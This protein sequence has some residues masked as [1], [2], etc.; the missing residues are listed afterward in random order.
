MARTIRK[1]DLE[2]I[3]EESFAEAIDEAR[4]LLSLSDLL[5][6]LLTFFVMLFAISSPDQKKLT[7]MTQAMGSHLGVGTQRKIVAPNAN[8]MEGVRTKVKSLITDNNLVNDVEL[9]SDS[10][11]IVLFSKGDF[12]FAPGG[13]ELLPDTVLF[14]HK[15]AELIRKS[16]NMVLVE[17]HTDDVPT[18][19]EKFPSNWE[20]STARA[21]AVVRY[22]IET[23]KLDPKQFI[24]SGYGEYKPRFPPT[25]ENRGQNRRVEIVIMTEPKP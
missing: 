18:H 4:W 25:P 3:R 20:L 19:S 13:T 14:L 24:V 12:F 11:G 2:T 7:E 1:A 9:T 23:E 15:V 5:T 17:G 8:P 22:F 6:L 10:R 16:P 21:A